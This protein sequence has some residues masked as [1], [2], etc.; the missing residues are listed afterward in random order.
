[1]PK[2]STA[3]RSPSDVRWV[4]AHRDMSGHIAEPGPAYMA[5]IY[6][7]SSDHIAGGHVSTSVDDAVAGAFG[8]L[9]V[10]RGARPHVIACDPVVL[11]PVQLQRGRFDPAPAVV[12]ATASELLHCAAVFDLFLDSAP[13]KEHDEACRLLDAPARTFLKSACWTDRADSQPLLIDVDI[14]GER[15][16]GVVCVMGNDGETWGVSVFPNGPAFAAVV[17]SNE[18]S[19][20]ADG[21]VSCVVDPA[22]ANRDTR[23]AVSIATA[24]RDGE[25]C[26]AQGSE[27]TLLHVVLIAASQAPSVGA[28][29]PVRGELKGPGFR[30]EFSVWDIEGA[31]A[32]EESRK[33][34]SIA[35]STRR[36]PTRSGL[37]FEV[38]PRALTKRLVKADGNH[39]AHE[40]FDAMPTSEGMPAVVVE[41]LNDADARDLV[42][43]I[44]SGSYLGITAVAGPG[45]TTVRLIGLGD[46]IVLGIVGTPWPPLRGF[47]RR[48]EGSR[49]LHGIVVTSRDSEELEGIFV[50]VLPQSY[51]Q[52]SSASAPTRKRAVPRSRHGT[53]P[54]R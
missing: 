41:C 12:A 11:A 19:M 39:L 3:R 24:I 6:D 21:T 52:T 15:V 16:G 26:S 30:A 50:C 7:P 29:E 43:R 37:A 25:P 17:E 8:E 47:M 49:G 5:L 36:R 31:Q 4:V 46:P 53:K 22:A 2:S 44:T 20:P 34:Q 32:A 33:E 9:K 28:A 1:M 10:P 23:P 27:V 48:R 42:R 35:R 38:L 18:P 13:H 14:D 45:G 54:R 51:D 40:C